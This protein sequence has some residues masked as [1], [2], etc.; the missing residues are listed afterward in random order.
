MTKHGDGDLPEDHERL[1]AMTVRLMMAIPNW[2]NKKLAEETGYDPKLIAHWVAGRRDPKPEHLE[3]VAK[4]IG[5]SLEWYENIA[6]TAIRLRALTCEQ[7]ES[8]DLTGLADATGR[9]IA[10]LVEAAFPEV[11][12]LIEADANEDRLAARVTRGG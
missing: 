3:T 11:E 8:L 7:R 12:A 5:V 2:S 6:R 1:G 10:A 4:A 9:K